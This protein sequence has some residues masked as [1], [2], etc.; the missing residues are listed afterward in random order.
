MSLTIKSI[1]IALG[2]ASISGS[3]AE[4][5]SVSPTSIGQQKQ[6]TNTVGQSLYTF[7]K[8]LPEKSNCTQLC[9]LAWPPFVAPI[10]AK[11]SRHWSILRRPTG[12]AQWAYKGAPLYTYRF[13]FKLGD[14]H[15]DGAEG[16]WHLARP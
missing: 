13:D 2:I 15:G 4:A 5:K 7:D 8:D 1:V 6:L 12:V 16:V 11:A 10:G 3:L 9:A 14:I